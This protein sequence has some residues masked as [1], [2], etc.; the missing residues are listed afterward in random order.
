[1]IRALEADR[2]Q[3]CNQ[4]RRQFSTELAARYLGVTADTLRKWRQ[5]GC[6]PM[7]RRIH[8]RAMYDRALL[9]AFIESHACV[10]TTAE[11]AAS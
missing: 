5:K 10:T 2:T 3:D 9:D 6:G 8:N 4:G 7:W 11:A 1:M